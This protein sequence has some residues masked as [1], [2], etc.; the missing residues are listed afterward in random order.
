MINVVFRQAKI[1]DLAHIIDMLANDVLGADRE[2]PSLP[3]DQRY[4][5][6]FNAIEQDP[7]QFMVVAD[8]NDA[9]IGYLQLSFIPGLSRFGM[10]R[11]QIESVRI[12]A[13]CRGNGYGKI[14]M[15]WAIEE[16]RRRGCELVQLNTATSRHLAIKFYEDL[17]F[18][19]SH[20]GMKLALD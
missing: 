10:W 6:A 18:T 19:A 4:Y 1:Q 9:V 5:D 11:G 7:N 20:V 14:M 16:C 17:G 15:Q 2:D 8:L 12:A 3:L 13:H